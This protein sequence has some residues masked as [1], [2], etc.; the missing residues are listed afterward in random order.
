MDQSRTTNSQE[1]KACHT[2]HF[3]MPRVES[4][5]PPQKQAS[6]NSNRDRGR[7]QKAPLIAEDLLEV[8]SFWEEEN[9]FFSGIRP[10]KGSPCSSSYIYV[11]IDSTK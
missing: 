10:L 3:T 7:A 9:H 2:Y 8:D 5:T 6:Q 4:I 1:S 11:H